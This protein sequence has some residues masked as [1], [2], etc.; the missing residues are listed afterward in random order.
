MLCKTQ[1]KLT[2]VQVGLAN[3]N[4][5]LGQLT[6]ITNEVQLGRTSY[7]SYVIPL[8]HS[9]M[10]RGDATGTICSHPAYTIKKTS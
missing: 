10:Q 7:C 5:G 3:K 4:Q 9:T 2:N 8:V 6:Y 1:E